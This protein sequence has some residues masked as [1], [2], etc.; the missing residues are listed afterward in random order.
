[1]KP[2]DPPGPCSTCW[3]GSTAAVTSAPLPKVG[4][5]GNV[6]HD[7]FDGKLVLD[8]KVIRAATKSTSRSRRYR[9]RWSSP[10]SVARFT[11]RSGKTSSARE[12]WRRT[13]T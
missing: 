9:R 1:M 13:C 8:W 10:H 4:A 6:Y 3:V 5:G 12:R 7:G 11:A 2:F